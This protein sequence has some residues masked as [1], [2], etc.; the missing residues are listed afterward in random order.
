MIVWGT[1][2]S[3]FTD[4]IP[5]ASSTWTVWGLS[6]IGITLALYVFMADSLHS[7]HQG[8]EVIRT[9][10]PTRF[11]WP[12]FCVALTLMAAPVAEIGWR[13]ASRQHA[14][15]AERYTS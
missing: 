11:N 7:V 1:L 3:Q 5:A 14:I 8:L 15:P 10:L 13:I 2:A 12:L 9:V 4:R 6:A